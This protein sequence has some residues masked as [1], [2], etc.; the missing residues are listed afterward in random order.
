MRAR[1]R[2]YLFWRL[3]SICIC[4]FVTRFFLRR[5][6][7][8]HHPVIVCRAPFAGYRTSCSITSSIPFTRTFFR[9]HN[10]NRIRRP[11]QIH[12]SMTII[13]PKIQPTCI[14]YQR[15]I[16]CPPPK[17]CFRGS[18]IRTLLS[19]VPYRHHLRL[20]LFPVLIFRYC[21]FV[22]ISF[23]FFLPAITIAISPS[24]NSVARHVSNFCRRYRI[25]H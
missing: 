12:W 4:L 8:Q 19:I 7:L 25:G 17:W 11:F 18:T 10:P 23:Y 1:G 16:G 21:S 9:L 22:P 20:F 3:V 24:F 2:R 14:A 15:S 13:G 6:S 5:I